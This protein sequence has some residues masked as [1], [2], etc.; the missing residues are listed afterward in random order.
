[1]KQCG[2][3]IPAVNCHS[4]VFIILFFFFQLFF[5]FLFLLE[6]CK[7]IKCKNW[8]DR[9]KLYRFGSLSKEL[10]AKETIN[11]ELNC[12]VHKSV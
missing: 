5:M 4:L 1:M 8:L 9:I 10:K 3:S 2:A 6:K 7:K 11:Y 12:F